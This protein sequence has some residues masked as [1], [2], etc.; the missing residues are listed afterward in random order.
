MNA[1]MARICVL[2]QRAIKFLLSLS[3]THGAVLFDRFLFHRERNEKDRRIACHYGITRRDATDRRY[4]SAH[5]GRWQ[6]TR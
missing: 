4:R 2:T 1:L 6:F 3:R 5:G